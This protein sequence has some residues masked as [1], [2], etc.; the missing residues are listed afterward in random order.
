MAVA[1]SQIFPPAPT[2]TES[3]VP[4]QKGKVFIVTGGYSGVGKALASILFDAGGTVY[5][6]GRSEEKAQ[7]AIR[8]ITST[9]STEHHG[10]GKLEFLKVDL[11][12]LTTIKPAA[13]VFRSKESKLEVLFNNAG[14]SLTPVTA[15]STQ[16]L[17]MIMATNC[18]GPLLFTQCL[19]P[20][21]KAATEHS[22]P[23]STRIVWASSQVVDFAPSGGVKMSEIKTPPQGPG[24]RY[25]NS[26]AGN[27][28]LASEFARRTGVE[29]GIL[30]ITQNPG[31]L[32]TNILRDGPTWLP[33]L[34]SPLLYPPRFGAYTNLYCGLSPDLNLEEHSGGYVLPWGRVHPSPRKDI[35]NALKS[36]EDGGTGQAQEFWEWCEKQI[37]AYR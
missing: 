22:S 27:W 2:F 26:K 5:I 23:G 28:F 6:A 8:E 34:I 19:L 3:N 11:S 29:N 16:G 31:A 15:K 4:S 7:E 13:E 17:E 18:L 10:D 21:L 37:E 32:K 36:K 25:M 35:L 24:K 12:D 20:A 14:V 9:T 33:W 30:S 1:Y